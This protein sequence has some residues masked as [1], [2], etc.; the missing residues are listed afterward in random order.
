MSITMPD[1]E[2]Q[3]RDA[4]FA[5]VAAWEYQGDGKPPLLHKE[6]LVFEHVRPAQRSYQ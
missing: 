3:R 6:P 4:P 2:A 5:Y 1:G